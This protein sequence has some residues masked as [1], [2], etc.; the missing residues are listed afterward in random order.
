MKE[1]PIKTERKTLHLPEDTVRALNK[2]AAKNGTDF[3]KEV[4]RAIDEYLDL[5]TTAENIDMINGV[6][7]QELSGQLKALGNRLA[8]LINRLTIISA[9]GYYANIAIIADLIDQDRYSSF[10]KIESAARKR[11]LAFANQKNADALFVQGFD[12]LKEK[13]SDNIANTIK[14]NCQV[15]AYLQSDDPET[16]REM[17]DKLGSYTT[18]S[19]Q[20]SASNGK[21]TTP[22]NS[23]SVSLTE[24]KLLNTD[25]VRRVKRPHQIITSR[26][27]PAMMYA[28]D[29]SQWM[30]NKMLGL[31]DMEHNRRLR[32]EREQKRPIITDTKQ[33]IALWNIWIYY[34]KDIMRRL[35][36]QKG[37]MG[38]GLDDD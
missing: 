21:Y 5:E 12:Q 3:S 29:L 26:D 1:S 13:Y 20:L 2:L 24:R 31:G 8:G 35:S 7:R 30:F 28:P 22:S 27:H 17:S 9:A 36:Q 34:Q 25:E 37:A 11:A 18:S 10:E 32:E 15:W 33:E 14:G 23:Q 19:Y 4:R 6:I 16:L 38:G